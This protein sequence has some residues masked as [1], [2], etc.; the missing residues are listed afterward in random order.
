MFNESAVATA[1]AF[2]SCEWGQRPSDVKGDCDVEEL[3]CLR[4]YFAVYPTILWSKTD[5]IQ[6][7]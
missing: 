2:A 4:R 5:F 3:M 7:L 6:F 1:R